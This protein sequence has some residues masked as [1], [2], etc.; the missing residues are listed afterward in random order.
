MNTPWLPGLE[1]PKR[2][3]TDEI[4]DPVTQKDYIKKTSSLN[5]LAIRTRL[6]ISFTVRKL[7]KA[8]ANLSK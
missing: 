2:L 3:L 6:D 8:N 7:C 1:L 5:Y 4:C